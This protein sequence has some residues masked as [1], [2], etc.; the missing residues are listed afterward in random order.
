MTRTGRDVRW[1]ADRRVT[2]ADGVVSFHCFSFGE[3][4]DPD[5]VAFGPLQAVNDEHLAPGSG[6]AAHHH[7]DVEILTWVVNGSLLHED[8]LG[9]RHVTTPGMVQRLSAGTGV[10]HSETAAVETRFVQMWVRPDRTGTSPDYAHAA[11]ELSSAEP[12]YA[13]LASGGGPRQV[14]AALTLGRDGASLLAARLRPA[15]SLRLPGADLAFLFVVS[16]E[17]ELDLGEPLA[18]GD[19]VRL[20]SVSEVVL[21]GRA[22]TAEILLWLFDEIHRRPVG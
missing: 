3:H 1:A 4:Y 22:E 5:N 18:A 2:A 17:V 13:V 10:E 9:G 7:S 14:Q 8:S 12:R 11:V 19:S 20:R 21:T 16:G 6:F 15:D